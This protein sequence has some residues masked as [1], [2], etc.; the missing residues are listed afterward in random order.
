MYGLLSKKNIRIPI[1]EQF[2]EP[3]LPPELC[4][5]WAEK[6]FSS[7]KV[8]LGFRKFKYDFWGVGEDVWRR[9]C[10]HVQR[11]F[12]AGVDGGLSGGSSMCRPGSEDPHRCQRK[13]HLLSK[14]ICMQLA[15]HFK[16]KLP[17]LFPRFI[18]FTEHPPFKVLIFPRE[19]L[20]FLKDPICRWKL[21][22]FQCRLKHS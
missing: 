18:C 7:S 17:N 2:Q 19:I 11:T 1:K 14:L 12:F 4:D 3:P 22:C 6:I 20:Q 15:W 9:L 13:L 21:L 16:I 5:F 10:L 8:V